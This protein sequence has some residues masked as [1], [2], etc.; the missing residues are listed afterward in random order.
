MK[1][2]LLFFSVTFCVALFG[3]AANNVK[4]VFADSSLKGR[5]RILRFQSNFDKTAPDKLNILFLSH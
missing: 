5:I 4:D 3:F 2:L 1:K